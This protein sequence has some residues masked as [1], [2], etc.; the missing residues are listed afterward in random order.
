VAEYLVV[1]YL[2]LTRALARSRAR[3]IPVID[4]VIGSLC[5]IGQ[6]VSQSGC[7]WVGLVCCIVL[8]DCVQCVNNWYPCSTELEAIFPV[9]VTGV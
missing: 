8:C 4:D 5:G 2:Y 9:E 6:N 3:A 7:S 1:Q